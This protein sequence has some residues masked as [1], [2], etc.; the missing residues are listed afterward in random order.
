MLAEWRNFLNKMKSVFKIICPWIIAIIVV[1]FLFCVNV[2]CL[3]LNIPGICTFASNMQFFC[4]VISKYFAIILLGLVVWLIL[5]WRSHVNV[6]I[7]K[8]SIAG[9][10]FNLKNIDR[11]VQSNLANYLNT[12][13]SLFKIYVEKDNFD[14]VFESYHKVY[15]FL[16]LQMTYY[17][18]I[19]TTDNTIYKELDEMIKDL[20]LFLTANQTNYRRWY[21]FES[22]KEYKPIK[23]LQESYP[24]YENLKSAFKEIN[25]IM[26]KHAEKLKINVCKW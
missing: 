13:R 19:A 16:R 12:K 17:E 7:P 18:N 1:V 21:K 10:E 2:K 11:I 22:V 6:T 24:D 3:L 5:F 4:N 9:V 25:D 15:E 20:N 26:K 23:E 8:I 14:D